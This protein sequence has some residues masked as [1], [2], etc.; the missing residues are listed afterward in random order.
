M[1]GLYGTVMM[2]SACGGGSG[3]DSSSG[4]DTQDQTAT[5]VVRAETPTMLGQN[6]MM[7]LDFD[8]DLTGFSFTKLQPVDVGH[9]IDS[10]NYAGYDKGVRFEKG[11][12]KDQAPPISCKFMVLNKN[13]SFM[14][15]TGE[16]Q[17]WYKN[18]TTYHEGSAQGLNINPQDL[19]LNVNKNQLTINSFGEFRVKYKGINSALSAETYYLVVS[20]NDSKIKSSSGRLEA[21]GKTKEQQ[22]VYKVE[23]P[24]NFDQKN[25][26]TL[27]FENLEEGD[28]VNIYAKADEKSDIYKPKLPMV[29]GQYIYQSGQL[30]HVKL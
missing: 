12:C 15:V 28:T 19:Y 7:P 4:S 6:D 21:V 9:F 13:K 10:L 14:L 16:D 22:L 24:Q 27:E 26:L 23:K 5:L 17:Y 29:A 25:S 30:Q 20:N 11:S 3:S 1:I 2:L 8:M 18:G